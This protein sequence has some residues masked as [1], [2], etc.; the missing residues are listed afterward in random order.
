[1]ER[2]VTGKPA[3]SDAALRTQACAAVKIPTLGFPTLAGGMTALAL[4]AAGIVMAGA[5]GMALA[6]SQVQPGQAMTAQEAERQLLEKT[7]AATQ[8][9][10]DNR[11][12]EAMRLFDEIIATNARAPQL[13]AAAH[14][15]RGIIYQKRGAFNEA[16][17][18]YT[19]A[20]WLD[21]LPDNMRA[22][23]HYNRGTAL[24][25]LGQQDRAKADF[26]AAIA[27]MPEMAPAYNNR[28]NVLRRM[29][30][31]EAAIADYDTSIALGNPL[32]HLP[33]YGR[34]AAR[35]ALGDIEGARADLEQAVSLA[36]DYAPARTALADLPEAPSAL[37]VAAAPQAVT[38]EPVAS[39]PVAS[40][41]VA[42]RAETAVTPVETAMLPAPVTP[43]QPLAAANDAPR[44]P[45]VPGQVPTSGQLATAPR[46]PF[47]QQPGM[48]ARVATTAPESGQQRVT[49]ASTAATTPAQVGGRWT[50][51][52]LPA[53]SNQ[54]IRLDDAGPALALKANE[55]TQLAAM[56]TPVTAPAAA[57]MGLQPKKGLAFPGVPAEAYRSAAAEPT[58]Q[59]PVRQAPVRQAASAGAGSGYAVQ[60]GSFRSETEAEAAWQAATR[61]LG[62][63]LQDRDH[64][65]QRAD[66]PGKG[67]YYRLRVGPMS[68]R[69]AA[70]ALC[71]TLK[72]QGQDCYVS[73]L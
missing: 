39:P 20:L 4:I 17:S 71:S 9:L 70:S 6:Q 47:A 42:S 54:A 59:A 53:G 24:D 1:M 15:H 32:P 64:L 12:D 10:I 26:D 66:I 25:N 8:A 31:Y 16:A 40:T 28:A 50:T 38:A 56:A 21:A 49:T 29:G 18:D 5:P 7:N 62:P 19:T 57:G 45:A 2:F 63:A 34:A 65:V 43:V 13:M 52:I 67:I 55:E 23:T 48:A 69:T 46:T 36:P 30:E 27:L 61:R 11:L 44:G 35:E 14:Y 37:T 58:R 51:T 41:P 72:S 60:L 3:K 73:K 68:A 33:H 22:R